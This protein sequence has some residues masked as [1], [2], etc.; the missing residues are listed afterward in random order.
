MDNKKPLKLGLK[1]GNINTAEFAKDY[2]DLKASSNLL[3]RTPPSPSTQITKD[4]HLTNQELI[5]RFDVFKKASQFSEEGELLDSSKAREIFKS[6]FTTQEEII[7]EIIQDEVS[8]TKPLPNTTISKPSEYRPAEV[9]DE[10][11]AKSPNGKSKFKKNLKEK[12]KRKIEFNLEDQSE[13]TFHKSKKLKSHNKQQAGTQEKIIREIELYTSITASELANKMS[14][15]VSDVIKTLIN[16]GMIADANKTLDLD[17]AELIVEALGH[18]FKRVEAVTVDSILKGEVDNSEDLKPRPPIVTVMGHVDHGKTSLLDAIRSTDVAGKEHRGITQSIGAYQIKL[19]NGRKIT[20]IDTP[21]HE[22][23]TE[24]RSRGA[25][26]TDIV[27]LIVAA[28]DGINHQTVEAINHIKAANLPIIVAVNKI[29]KVDDPEKAVTR[30][31]N[32]LLIHNLVA[33][34]MG[35]DVIFVPISALKKINLDRLEESI[36]LLADLLELKTNLDTFGSGVILD[37]KIDK[38]RGIVTS[39]LLTRGTLRVGDPIVSGGC[40]GKIRAIFTHKKESVQFI[41]PSTPAT[42]IGMDSV[43]KAGDKFVAIENEK[44]A[45]QIAEQYS[46]ISKERSNKLAA[47]L[48]KSTDLF[49]QDDSKEFAII[50]KADTGGS[51]EAIVSSLAKIELNKVNLR[52]LHSGVGSVNDSDAALASASNVPILAFNT[53]ATLGPSSNKLQVDIR[54]HS[55]IYDL[56]DDV[57]NMMKGLVEPTYVKEFIGQ[58]SVRQ[59]FDITKAGKIAGSYVTKG[60]IKRDAYGQVFRGQDLVYE[61]KIKTLKRFKDDVKEVKETFECGIAFEDFSDMQVEDNIKVFI[62]V[63][64]NDKK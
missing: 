61:G 24:M 35:G 36:L 27:I 8:T 1:L 12:Y 4:S 10:N 17:T 5:K 43:P 15:K 2:A 38:H 9:L 20:L 44:Q 53:K 11:A 46:Y 13:Q 14:E 21:G 56:I 39:I 48:R 55:I 64:E 51:I 63:E 7:S 41:E 30:I 32:E 60:V 50:I 26:I 54:H 62:Y 40:C 59:I 22:A 29:D 25:Q 23:F 19:P 37:A 34:D 18:R 16:L 42:I 45:R 28:D 31:K 58:A 3:N 52:I 6:N 57:T 47:E 49:A 33:E